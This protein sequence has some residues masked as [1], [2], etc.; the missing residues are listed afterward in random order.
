VHAVGD[1][2]LAAGDAV[3]V[4]SALGAGGDRGHVRA[5]GRL[6]DRER[7]HRLAAR[8]AGQVRSLLRVGPV[9]GEPRRRHV[10]VDE[11]AEGDAARAAAGHLLAED[12]VREEVAV[13]AA[14]FGGESQAEEAELAEAAP[15]RA[16]DLARLLPCVDVG[17]NL[18]LDERADGPA[19]QR[20]LRGERPRRGHRPLTGRGRSPP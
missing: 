9:A 2:R 5:R 18:A 12:D 7:A 17:R 14:V 1:E 15:E 6:G 4:A 13:A 20:V 19:E 8:D 11:H 3:L 10:G 16:G